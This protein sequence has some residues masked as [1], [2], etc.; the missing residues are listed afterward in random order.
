MNEKYY[1][2]YEEFRNDTQ[3]LKN[4]C[5]EFEPEVILAIAR[6]GLCLGQLLSE[7]MDIRNLFTL[8]SIH[9][10]DTKKLDSFDIFNIPDLKNYK[11]I[12][13]VDDIIDSGESMVE[14]LK[15]LNHKFPNYIFKTATLFRKQTALMQPD[16]SVKEANC[17]IEF[18]WEVDII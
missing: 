7:A 8:N 5:Q 9:Y 6:G 4:K 3:V 1:Y 17:W 12:L 11:K 13:I 16:Y 2:S 18:F 14:I 15:I 10:N